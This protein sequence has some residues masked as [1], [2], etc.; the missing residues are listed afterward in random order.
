M[1]V[2]ILRGIPGAGKTTWAR[3][4]AQ[5]AIICSADH[6]FEKDGVYQFNPKMLSQAHGACLKKFVEALQNGDQLVVVDNTNIKIQHLTP[7]VSLA[8]AYNYKVEIRT[9][10]VPMLVGAARNI[11]SVP[12]ATIQRM[13]KEFERL[14]KQW[15]NYEVC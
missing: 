5:D 12:Q 2:V 10:K 8:E 3:Q 9:L 6:F 1:K 15:L 4:N 14:P 13:E 11:H 7:Y